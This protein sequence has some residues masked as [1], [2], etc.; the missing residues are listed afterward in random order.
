MMAVTA[1]RSGAKWRSG[2]PV[3]ILVPNCLLRDA[4]GLRKRVAAGEKR[5]ALA[6]EFGISRE[7]VPGSHGRDPYD[8]QIGGHKAID[9]AE[10][11]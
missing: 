8:C 10:A 4:K 5:A 7:T 1:M 2:R 11:L 9:L 6:R 3:K